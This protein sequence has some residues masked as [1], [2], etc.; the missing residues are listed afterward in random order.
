MAQSG[1]VAFVSIEED[2]VLQVAEHPFG[3]TNFT[4]KR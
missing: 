3:R 2:Q 1:G 4:G